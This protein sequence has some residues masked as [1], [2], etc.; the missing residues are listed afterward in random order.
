VSIVIL[1]EGYVVSRAWLA[2][3]YCAFDVHFWSNFDRHIEVGNA[4]I[5][6]VGSTRGSSSSYRIVAGGMFGVST[7]KKDVVS[8]GPHRTISCDTNADILEIEINKDAMDVIL[9]ESM[10]FVEDIGGILIVICGQM[11]S[12]PCRSAEVLKKNSS[13]KDIQI[14][15][16]CDDS[17]LNEYNESYLDD[18]FT[19]ELDVLKTLNKLFTLDSEKIQAII[20][21]STASYEMGQILM[22]I[23]SH[24][25]NKRKMLTENTTVISVSSDEGKI[26][27]RNFVNKFLQNVLK[28]E[29]AFKGEV[30][31]KGLNS[32]IYL[33]VASK[34]KNFIKSLKVVASKVEKETEITSD[35]INLY[36]GQVLD[37]GA[38]EFSRWFKHTDYD[39]ESSLK[40]WN[41]QAQLEHQTIFQLEKSAS[42]FKLSAIEITNALKNILKLADSTDSPCGKVAVKEFISIGDGIV[43]TALWSGGRV[44]VIWDGRNHVDV[45]V[46]TKAGNDLAD[47]FKEH[48][49]KQIPSLKVVL[50][51]WQPRGYGQVVNF[52]KDYLDPS[53]PIWS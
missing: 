30:S 39:H 13:Y 31:F 44:I 14:L 11:D 21:D 36:G 28:E 1:K 4:L 27:Q 32:N 41:S 6:A 18:M 47:I 23:F 7:W 26:W 3:E 35:I 49:V 25:K 5:S 10:E 46:C 15:W 8:R 37:R 19:C 45:N 48:F 51:D 12:A 43:L 52:S 2:H 17:D 53:F 29:P 9:E 50:H 42:G 22:K 34:D 33:N 16:S 24:I 40:Q 38:F 20:F